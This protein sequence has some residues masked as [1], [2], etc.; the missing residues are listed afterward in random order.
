MPESGAGS[1]LFIWLR[2]LG[3][4]LQ[5]RRCWRQ[6]LA[7]QQG[8]AAAAALLL[9][10]APDTAANDDI[11]TFLPIH[12]AAAA[13]RIAVMR[14]LLEAAPATAS[15]R[16]ADGSTPLRLA[17]DRGGIEAVELLLEA[18]PETATSRDE[19]GSMPLHQAAAMEGD[20]TAVD[21]LLEVAPEAAEA[22]DDSGSL[23]LDISL[24][25]SAVPGSQGT[26]SKSA[27]FWQQRRLLQ[28]PQLR[29]A[30]Q[31]CTWLRPAGAPLWSERC[32][33]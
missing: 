18:A 5:W 21:L 23:P 25:N 19:N 2:A 33:H 30:E 32:W 29:R 28:Q 24:Y 3:A 16:T 10:A 9:G 6:T 7:L 26:A 1:L 12:H 27:L 15:A 4:Q 8:H 17:A 13:G 20:A 22:C 11:R 31:R 14:L